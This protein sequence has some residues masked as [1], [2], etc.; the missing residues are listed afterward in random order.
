MKNNFY[1][2]DVNRPEIEFLSEVYFFVSPC[3]HFPTFPGFPPSQLSHPIVNISTLLWRD[4]EAWPSTDAVGQK[5]G[6]VGKWES[7]TTDGCK[8]LDE[9]ELLLSSTRQSTRDR[10]SSGGSVFLFS[11]ARLSR[12][13]PNFPLINGF[14]HLHTFYDQDAHACPCR[15]LLRCNIYSEY[16]FFIYSYRIT[17]T[18]AKQAS[19]A[20]NSEQLFM[21]L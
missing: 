8:S 19:K 2:P 5:G 7:R 9:K 17:A 13:F 11:L 18:Q 20:S 10:I 16:S 1:F 12:R 3:S 6:K 4:D 14:G 21:K 15:F